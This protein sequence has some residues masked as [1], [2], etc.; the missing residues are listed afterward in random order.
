[1]DNKKFARITSLIRSFG[2]FSI[3]GVFGLLTSSLGPILPDL[4]SQVAAPL[5]M[6]SLIFT[7]RAFGF[8]FGSLLGGKLFDKY[9]S[10]P[11]VRCFLLGPEFNHNYDPIQHVF[12][13]AD[14]GCFCP[15]DHV[16]F[17]S[18]GGV[19][20]YCVGASTQ[21]GPLVEHAKLY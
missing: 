21:P 4:S 2:Y 19:H 8:L 18:G 10:H 12:V 15:G 16:G 1:L 9:K 17:C 13:V 6:L 20:V 5:D 7:A 3:M 11:P 14:R